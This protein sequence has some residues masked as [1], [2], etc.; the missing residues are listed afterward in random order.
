MQVIGLCR[1]SY[2]A[3]GG[4]QVAH[5]TPEARMA[6]LYAPD[7]MQERFRTFETI[8]LP[9]LKSQTD[10]DFTLL[11]VTG[12]SLPAVYRDRLEALVGDMPQVVIQ[13]H[14]PGPHRQVMQDAVNS[15]RRFDGDPCLQFRMDD[16]DAVA[17]TYV[18]TLRTAAQDVRRMA[19]RHR[20]IAIDFNQGF[21]LR[22]DADGLWAAPTQVPYTTAALAVMLRPDVRLS[23][24][25]FAHSKVAQKMPTVTFT[26]QDMLIRGHND[27]NDSRQ[28]KGVKP[29]RLERL[30]QDGEAYIRQVFGIDADQVRRL[31]SGG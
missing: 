30:E 6:Y 9:P 3:I 11:I 16:D 8:M 1:F 24:M 2:P 26:G 20:H 19:D 27:Y 31:Y 29:V 14:P 18:E 28:K 25:N 15:L 13:T 5:D 7:R 22:P 12:D 23:I 17:R 21:I 4:F 10:D